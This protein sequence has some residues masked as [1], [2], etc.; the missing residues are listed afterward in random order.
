MGPRR[1]Q[2]RRAPDRR[3][4]RVCGARGGPVR[5][6]RPPGARD[7]RRSRRGRRHLG[8]RPP[9]PAPG[10]LGAHVG[11]RSAVRAL[12]RGPSRTRHRRGGRRRRRRRSPWPPSTS[13]SSCPTP[14]CSS[15]GCGGSSR[16]GRPSVVV[17]DC[18]L[19]GPVAGACSPAGPVPCGVAPGPPGGRTASSTTSSC[20]PAWRSSTAR[21]STRSARTT[22]RSRSSWPWSETDDETAGG[23]RRAVPPLH[24]DRSGLDLVPLRPPDA[25]GPRPSCSRKRHSARGNRARAAVGG[26]AGR[27]GRTRRARW[28]ARGRRAA[29]S[30]R[31]GRPSRP[32]S[33]RRSNDAVAASGRPAAGRSRCRR[34]R[35]SPSVTWVA[36]NRVPSSSRPAVQLQPK[37]HQSRTPHEWSRWPQPSNLDPLVA[38]EDLAVDPA[39]DLVAGGGGVGVRAAVGLPLEV[40][41]ER[42]PVAPQVAVR[43]GRVVERRRR[44]PRRRPTSGRAGSRGVRRP[45]ALGADLEAR[46]RDRH[47]VVDHGDQRPVL[48]DQAGPVPGHAEVRVE[49]EAH[50]AAELARPSVKS[51]YHDSLQSGSRPGLV[52]ALVG[53]VGGGGDERRSRGAPGRPGHG[54]GRPERTGAPVPA[55]RVACRPC[56]AASQPSGWPP[57][58]RRPGPARRCARR[59][60][61]WTSPCSRWSRRRPTERTVTWHVRAPTTARSAVRPGRADAPT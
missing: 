54:R 7:H 42:H 9:V 35:S 45:Q 29:T 23:D 41:A 22:S 57:S 11:A 25:P 43:L 38:D 26:H 36:W 21:C 61:S 39:R 55:P 17:G 12:G 24:A 60:P 59:P 14:R 30:P 27:P 52:A 8:D 47:V 40:E 44:R 15:G 16:S 4:P 49:A 5:Q 13:R 51:R 31:S 20:R 50:V 18:N 37:V 46:L 3:R 53:G 32:S 58:T 34:P 28:R 1:R 19:W 6:S 56:C 10:A 2:R 48:A 33:W